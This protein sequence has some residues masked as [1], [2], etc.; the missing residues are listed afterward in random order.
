M[1]Q[2]QK[3]LLIRI[4]VSL[5]LYAAASLLQNQTTSLILL[6]PYFVAGWD[7]LYQ[8]ARNIANGQLFD[9]NF[10]MAV[11]TV[12]ALVL[13]EFPEAVFVMV[14]YQVGE[15]F[16]SYAVGRSRNSIAGL[17]ELAPDTA[18]VE[19]HGN[20]HA[21]TPEEIEVGDLLVVK[22]G[23]KIPTD[24][25]VEFGSSSLNTAALTG[26]SM[27]RDV[28][29]GDE[30]ISGC[31]NLKG[32]LKIRAEKEFSDS[33]VSK[34]LEL[35][36]NAASSKAKTEQFIT[37]FA[38][39]Y[40]PVVVILAVFLAIIPPLIGVGAW[41]E[42]L[43]R[44]LTF[45]MVSCPCALVI[46]VPLSFFGGIGRASK[47]GILV[48]GSNYMEVL[49]KAKTVVFD[50]TGTLTKGCFSVTEVFPQGIE[51]Q[52]LIRLAAIAESVSDHP[53]A[54][55]LRQAY[56]KDISQE[57]VGE[58][59]EIPGYGIQ[60]EIEGKAILA[61]NRRLMEQN[62]IDYLPIDHTGTHV[63]VAADG[64]YLGA[65][66]ISDQVKDDAQRA[67]ID[68]Q[69]QGVSRLVMLTGDHQSAAQETAKQLGISEVHGELL[70]QDK[71]EQTKRIL[72]E[73][74]EGSL[75]FVGDGMN[76]APVLA[77]A[78]AGIAMGALGSDAA[79]EAADV[80]LMDD[81]LSR[82]AQAVEIAKKTMRVVWQ[83]ILFALGIKL[84][85]LVLSAF[86]LTNMWE[87]VIAD[88]G[89]S[90]LAIC[91]AMRAMYGKN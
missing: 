39:Y 17:M 49:S 51:R 10:L 88:V 78:D 19:R 40:T 29:P 30:V 73:Q 86:G 25:V 56:G 61:G 23:E 28:Q 16:Q 87:A 31:I 3:N 6:I 41:S 34:I 48:K 7:V 52:E 91:N 50:K 54:Q 84:F 11:A 68:L 85:V 4:L 8:A 58:A 53:I 22:P 77:M 47:R 80:V 13:K 37:R 9:E 21:I 26:E 44:A 75:L 72:A 2:K 18:L 1:H 57:E 90:V 20:Q 36:E 81:K 65:I 32:L 89:V 45:L 14:F 5:A 79:I 66:V 42:W 71:V 69:K 12:G 46:S 59:K 27:L 74:T 33:T 62:H 83:N 15:L 76:D 82:L 43:R 35:V 38:R 24:G 60:A 70:P 67:I 63:Y 55:S 64:V